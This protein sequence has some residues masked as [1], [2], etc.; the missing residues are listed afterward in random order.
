[1]ISNETVKG[2]PAFCRDER[3][4]SHALSGGEYMFCER[5]PKNVC[6]SSV[7][8]IIDLNFELITS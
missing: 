5:K 8:G 2:N 6:A 1:M 3:D 4:I 7:F